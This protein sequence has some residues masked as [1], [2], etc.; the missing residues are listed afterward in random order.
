MPPDN[1]DAES[2]LKVLAR[3]APYACLEAIALMMISK[4]GVL[5]EVQLRNV[6]AIIQAIMVN[7]GSPLNAS[8]EEFLAQPFPSPDDPRPSVWERLS[9]KDPLL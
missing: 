2:L 5:H 6:V 3:D 8:I 1:P 9:G 4:K 7:H